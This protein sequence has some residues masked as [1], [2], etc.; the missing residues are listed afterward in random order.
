[1]HNPLRVSVRGGGSCGGG[2]SPKKK[3][4]RRHP[5]KEMAC[6]AAHGRSRLGVGGGA[7]Y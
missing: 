3:P 1:M 6:V 7:I 2:A 4:S 5:R